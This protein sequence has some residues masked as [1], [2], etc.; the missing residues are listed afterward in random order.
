MLNRAI[1]KAKYPTQLKIARV[2]ALY[3]KGNHYLANNYRPISLLSPFNKIFEK[4]IC[5]Q[6]V[7]FL[8]K[9]NIL[10]QYQLGFRRMHSTTLALIEITDNLRKL[11][12]DGNYALSLFIDLT[13]HSILLITKYYFTKWTIMALEATRTISF[14]HIWPAETVYLN[15]WNTIN[16]K[17]CPT[18]FC[19]RAYH[20]SYLYQWLTHRHRHWT[21]SII[22]RWCECNFMLQKPYWPYWRM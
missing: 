18:R 3:K 8:E 16:L 13:K 9:N 11:L 12:N 5:R 10:F 22:C 1:G 15:K 14:I 6:L 7:S 4:I 2:V 20:V 19:V 17:R 21:Y